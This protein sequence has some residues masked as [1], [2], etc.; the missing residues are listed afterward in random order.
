MFLKLCRSFLHS[1]YHLIRFCLYFWHF[2]FCFVV[3]L[4]FHFFYS[5]LL[6]L[7]Y[8]FSLILKN[9]RDFSDLILQK[10]TFIFHSIFSIIIYSLQLLLALL[11]FLDDRLLVLRNLLIYFFKQRL[12][13]SQHVVGFE[14]RK[15]L[16]ELILANRQNLCQIALQ[17]VVNWN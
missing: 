16:I 11:D 3:N 15:I 1:F 6:F 8:S 2:F 4:T 12:I 14:R 7:S 13:S 9:K 5:F 17:W 10:L